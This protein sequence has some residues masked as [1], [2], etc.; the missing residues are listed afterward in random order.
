M[1]K[2]LCKRLGLG[3]FGR[4]QKGSVKLLV[5]LS[6]PLVL[7]MTGAGLDTAELY[8]ARINF[9][10]AVDAGTLMAAKNACGNGQHVKS[11]DRW[12]R[13]FLC[14]HSLHC[15][16]HIPRQHNFRHGQW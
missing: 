12:R 9:Q 13:G 6:T 15:R 5:G 16:R 11:C 10:N 1:L 8:R 4:N 14:Q 2:R 3:K 7:L